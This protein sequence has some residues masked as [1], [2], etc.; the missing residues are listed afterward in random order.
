MH[1]TNHPLFFYTA[2]QWPAYGIANVF[3]NPL[4]NT[5]S[6]LFEITSVDSPCVDMGSVIFL[7]NLPD[8][9]ICFSIN[10]K[11]ALAIKLT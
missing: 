6:G 10:Q 5:S 3:A 7:C 1:L 9:F 2:D 8:N 11:S 4:V